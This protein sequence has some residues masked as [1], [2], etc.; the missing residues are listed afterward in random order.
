[1][2]QIHPSSVVDPKAELADDV[3]VGP[4]CIIGPNVRIGSGTHLRSHVVVD[5]C[6]TIGE[7]NVVYQGASIGCAPQDKKYRGEPTRLEIGDD[8]VIRENTTFSVGTVQDEGITRVG[9][10]GL[11]MVGSHVAHD[12]FVG[13]DVILANNVAL[14]GHVHVEDYVIM[15][16][17]AA[18]HQFVRIGERAMI[19]G[20]SAVLQ[21]VPPYMICHLNPCVP[22]GLNLVGLRRAGFSNEALR[23]LRQAYG[24]VYRENLTIAEACLKLDAIAAEIPCAAQELARLRDFISSSKRGIIRP[25]N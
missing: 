19:G 2:A 12:C 20:C 22:A 25:K 13:N 5:G 4:F 10:R 11:F 3:V 15:G 21:D 9:S 7:R 17:Q 16:G 8:N 24:A 18:A 14:A 1:M 23:A 6:T